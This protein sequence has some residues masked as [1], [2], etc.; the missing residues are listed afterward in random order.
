MSEWSDYDAKVC[1]SLPST[2]AGSGYNW[3]NLVVRSLVALHALS[4]CQAA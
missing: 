3:L 2:M 1:K 4:A